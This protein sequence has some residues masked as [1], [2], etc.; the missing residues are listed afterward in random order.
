MS[1]R[2]DRPEDYEKPTI[3]CGPGLTKQSHKNDSDINLIMSKYKK[4]GVI[5]FVNNRQAEYMEVPDTD[6]QTAMNTIT[7]ANQMFAEMPAALR[8][9]FGNDPGNFLSFV[10]DPKNLDEIYELGL[11]EPPEAWTS[12]RLNQ[13]PEEPEIEPEKAPAQSPS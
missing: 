2:V 1:F 7:E 8:K 6:F 12:A 4:T 5:N 3:D 9:K 10:H 11:V 13:A